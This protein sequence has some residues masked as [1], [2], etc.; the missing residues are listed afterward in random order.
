MTNKTLIKFIPNTPTKI[1]T[2]EKKEK[3]GGTP[4]LRIEKVNQNKVKE[5]KM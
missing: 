2:S 4:I 3:E 5:G 1:E